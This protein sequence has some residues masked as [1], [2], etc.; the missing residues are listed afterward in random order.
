MMAVLNFLHHAIMALTESLEGVSPIESR[1]ALGLNKKLC[2]G[3]NGTSKLLISLSPW[4]F[5][6]QSSV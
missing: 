1:M 4:Y 5:L 6:L 2:V 3:F